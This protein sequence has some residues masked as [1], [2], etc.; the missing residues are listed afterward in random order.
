VLVGSSTMVEVRV[1]VGGS[2]VAVVSGGGGS[3]VVRVVCGSSDEVSTTV[4]VSVVG[5]TAVVV[6]PTGTEAVGVVLPPPLSC[7]L[8]NSAT[9]LALDGA[10][11]FKTSMTSSKTNTSPASLGGG[12]SMSFGQAGFPCPYHILFPLEAASAAAPE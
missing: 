9:R 1:E 12:A 6:S 7:R 2:D 10:P 5:S 4:V 3:V 8:C 11:S